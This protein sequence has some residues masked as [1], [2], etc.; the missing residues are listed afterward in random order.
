[1]TYIFDE[2]RCRAQR[3]QG[4]D[5]LSRKEGREI[6]QRSGKKEIK[7]FIVRVPI[8]ILKYKCQLV[9]ETRTLNTAFCYKISKVNLYIFRVDNS[10]ND[11]N[12]E[13]L[14][15]IYLLYKAVHETIFYCSHK[16]QCQESNTMT[17][18]SS[19]NGNVT[20]K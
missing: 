15:I 9:V 7:V 16:I 20:S 18:L 1:M 5:E 10:G 8:G 4:G 3:A 2:L 11:Y 6:M 17:M 12:I 19:D 13:V 14:N